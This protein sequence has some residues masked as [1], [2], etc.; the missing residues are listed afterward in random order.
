M[1]SCRSINQ[2]QLLS[3]GQSCSR[4][5]RTRTNNASSESFSRNSLRALTASERGWSVL[6]L[7]KQRRSG[8][9]RPRPGAWWIVGA[10][11]SGKWERR[12]SFVARAALIAFAKDRPKVGTRPSHNRTVKTSQQFAPIRLSPSR[13]VH[14]DVLSRVGTNIAVTT[15]GMLFARL[16]RDADGDPGQALRDQ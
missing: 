4:V 11:E 7:P 16:A 3:W 13:S 15:G 6:V 8:W 10:N 9:R 2:K 5:S 14:C 1:R 12:R